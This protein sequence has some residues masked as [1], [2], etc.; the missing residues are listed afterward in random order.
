M[1]EYKKFQNPPSKVYCY[2]DHQM[3]NQTR[4]RMVPNANV[5]TE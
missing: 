3:Q 5:G 4:M 1:Y 2:V